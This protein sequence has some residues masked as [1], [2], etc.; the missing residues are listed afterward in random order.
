MNKGHCNLQTFM[1]QV[2]KKSG[3]TSTI[4]IKVMHKTFCEMPINFFWSVYA[5]KILAVSK[6]YV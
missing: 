4:K 3:Q 2:S 6:S 5:K 1:R